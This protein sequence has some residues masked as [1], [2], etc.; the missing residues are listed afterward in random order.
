[1]LVADPDIQFFRLHCDSREAAEEA[2]AAQVQAARREGLEVEYSA[3]VWRRGLAVLALHT[4]R[5]AVVELVEPVEPVAVEAPE[6]LAPEHWLLRVA[7]A[8]DAAI[9]VQEGRTPELFVA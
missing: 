3:V 6:P 4:R 8:Y 9:R 1:M 5:A 2:R 7:G